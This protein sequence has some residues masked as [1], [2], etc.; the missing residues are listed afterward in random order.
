M[1]MRKH[2]SPRSNP[3]KPSLRKS[4]R[5]AQIAT[6]EVSFLAFGTVRGAHAL[7]SWSGPGRDHRARRDG[8][9]QAKGQILNVAP[10]QLTVRFDA[11][12]DPTT[13]TTNGVAAIQFTRSVDNI[14]NNGNDVPIALGYS[15]AMRDN[16]TDVVVR[17]A[18]AL[19]T[20]T[21]QVVISGPLKS[22]PIWPSRAATPNR[23]LHAPV[24]TPSGLDRAATGHLAIRI[25]ELELSQV[26]N[27]HEI[28]VYFNVNDPLISTAM[29]SDPNSD[30]ART[31]PI[32]S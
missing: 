26:D 13:L 21:Y 9:W 18:S 16:P 22:R 6:I 28:D 32:S 29:P 30:S 15:A 8:V 19:P 7:R 4:P 25:S 12:M 17:F 5:A 24:G 20:D 3:T 23:I 1:A 14:L 27:G 31:R 11:A 10:T 2:S